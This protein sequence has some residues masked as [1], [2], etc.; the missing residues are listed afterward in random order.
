MNEIRLFVLSIHI[1]LLLSLLSFGKNEKTNANFLEMGEATGYV[2]GANIV[3]TM[4]AF[5]NDLFC[6]IYRLAEA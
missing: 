1:H 4:T 2:E 6:K 3:M 5:Y